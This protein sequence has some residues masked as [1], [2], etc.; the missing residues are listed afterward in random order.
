MDRKRVKY[1]TRVQTMPDLRQVVIAHGIGQHL[2][3]GQLPRVH[4]HTGA[5]PSAVS[6]LK[7]Q[8]RQSR[9]K[10]CSPGCEAAAGAARPRWCVLSAVKRLRY[11]V[12]RQMR[13][14]RV[15]TWMWGSRQWLKAVL[16][17]S[18]VRC[19]A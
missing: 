1:Q 14:F 3:A 6:R 18:S 13:S 5:V 16:V 17:P 19:T 4:I 2:E 15:F 10:V 11:Q 9:S 12:E 8:E 7:Y